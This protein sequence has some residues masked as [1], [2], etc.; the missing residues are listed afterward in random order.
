MSRSNATVSLRYPGSE[1]RLHESIRIIDGSE[2]FDDG[3][4]GYLDEDGFLY[5]TG[6]EKEMIISGGVNIYPLE[7]E[8]VILRHPAVFDVAVVRLPHPDL[9]EVPIA[10]V[11]RHGGAKATEEEI[12]SFC[13]EEN[14]YG[15]KLPAKVEFFSELPRHIDGKII[16]RELEER[17]WEEVARRG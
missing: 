17:Y 8:Q 10:C 12:I 9:G 2:W 13:K 7:I 6:R 15:Y 1:H 14:L 16:K 4:L 11:Q 5:L 3:L